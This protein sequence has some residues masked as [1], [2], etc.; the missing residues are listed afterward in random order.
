MRGTHSLV[1][2]FYLNDL[3]Y[4][5]TTRN[6]YYILSLKGKLSMFLDHN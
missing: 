6:H 3:G 5:N 1:K 2:F 4:R